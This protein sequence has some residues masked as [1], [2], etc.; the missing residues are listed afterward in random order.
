VE[1]GG[2]PIFHS[3][4]WW[5]IDQA[6]NRGDITVQFKNY[7]VYLANSAKGPIVLSKIAE[8]LTRREANTLAKQRRANKADGTQI[9][10]YNGNEPRSFF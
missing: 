9:A 4:F 10:V 3:F 8:N 5:S 1:D 6:S 2:N 7:S